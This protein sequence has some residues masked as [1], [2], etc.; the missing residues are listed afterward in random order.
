MFTEIQRSS[1]VNPSV[2]KFSKKKNLLT[3]ELIC[4]IFNYIWVAF[5]LEKKKKKTDNTKA[6]FL[7]QVLVTN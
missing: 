4:I 1:I 3:W 7:V 6:S 5:Y 2:I